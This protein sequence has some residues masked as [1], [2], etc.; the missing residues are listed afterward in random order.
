VIEL[1]SQ[2]CGLVRTAKNI[3]VACMNNVVHNFH[4]KVGPGI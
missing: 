3:V 2:P 4:V 1:E